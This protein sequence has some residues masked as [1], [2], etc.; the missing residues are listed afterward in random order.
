LKPIH[1][2]KEVLE[3]VKENPGPTVA[4]RSGNEKKSRWLLGGKFAGR[5]G[6]KYQGQ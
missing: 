2:E 3:S 4:F 6:L 5:I 1:K